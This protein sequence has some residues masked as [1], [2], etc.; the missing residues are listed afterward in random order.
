MPGGEACRPAVFWAGGSYVYQRPLKA[1]T[2]VQRGGVPVLRKHI[3]LNETQG[4][5]PMERSA[6]RGQ[7]FGLHRVR[8]DQA[9][10]RE[11]KETLPWVELFL[12]SECGSLTLLRN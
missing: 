9:G 3:V 11:T 7:V 1:R 5:I 8:F 4:A 6:L 2:L 10:T 12:P